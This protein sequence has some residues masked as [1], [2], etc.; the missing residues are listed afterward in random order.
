MFIN[1]QYMFNQRFDPRFIWEMEE[2]YFE[3][4]KV[5]NADTLYVMLFGA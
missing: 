4:N 5:S 3:T 1:D 2:F